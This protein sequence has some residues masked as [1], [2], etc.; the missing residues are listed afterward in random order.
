ME[1]E[2]RTPGP[3]ASG[4][5]QRVSPAQA[6][7]PPRSIGDIG[8][9]I[10][11]EAEKG[12][13]QNAVQT[14]AKAYLMSAEEAAKTYEADP[15]F[16]LTD[17]EAARRRGIYG[18]NA[19]EKQKKTGLLKQ[20]LAQLKDV[21]TIILIIAG[22]LSLTMSI[23]EWEGVHSLIEPLVVF[24]IIVMNVIL[25]VTQE[26]SAE[27]ALEALSSLSSPVC[28]VVRGGSVREADPA[29][30]VPGDLVMLKTGDLVPADARL[31][32]SESLAADE[33]SL[34][35]ES[36]PA[37]KD[38]SATF[39][40]EAPLGDRANCVYSGCLVTAGNAAAVVTATGMNTEMGKIARFLTDTKNK[41]TTL[42]VRL[43]KVGKVIS[44]IAVMS[45]V[46]LFVTGLIQGQGIMDMLLVAITLAVAAVP[47]TLALIVTLIL[48]YGAKKMATK[49]A[50]V[51]QMQAVETLGSTSVICSDKTGTLT[52]NKMTVK[53]LWVYGGEPVAESG[54]FSEG[55]NEFL[56]N[57]CLA[58]AAT[59]GTDDEG[60][61]KI[62][63]DPTETAIVRLAMEK[64]IDYQN[65]G[66]RYKKVA[67]IPF[68]SARKMMTNVIELEDGYLVLTKGA[69]DRLPF[70]RSDRNYMY[71]LERVHDGFAK[72]ALRV[73]ALASKKIDRLP[74]DI[75][76]VESGLTFGG[77]VG[78]IDPPRPEAAAAI[79]KAK[80]AG[81]RTVM[82]TGDHAATAGAIAR[83]LG[84]IAANEGVITGQE[85]ASLSDEELA[86]SVEFYSVYARVSPEDK[87]RIVKAWQSRG[88][89]VAMTGDGVNDAP[90]LKAADVGVA[91]G[92][93]GT[94]VSKSAAKMIL[95]DD[96]FSTIIEAVA[97]GRNIFSNI[98]KLVY[99]LLVCNISEILVMLFAQFMGWELPLTPLMLLII[100][101]L[102]DGIP[103][104]ALAKEESDKRIMKRKPISRNES[105]FGGGL[106]E[107]IIQQ[108]FVFAIVTL[109]GYYIGTHV[110]FGDTLPS[111]EAGRTMAFL[112]TGWTS[113]L[114]VLTV[115]SR[116]MLYK[117]RIK[118]NPQLYISCGVMLALFAVVA[119]VP[120]VASALGLGALGWQQ[121]LIVIAFSLVPL[122]VAEYGK[123]WDAIKSR[124]AERTAVR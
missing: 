99:F 66:S 89:V 11:Q 116:S 15:I 71:E 69:F 10:G 5:N 31:I 112:I 47:E 30:L 56:L 70:D 33:S 9:S 78:I 35:G 34:T 111:L 45:A 102:G 80:A 110:Q 41:K 120:P 76:D 94:E 61:Q 62:M 72:D 115:R 79:A 88:E 68:S 1:E 20:I 28:R 117:Y 65:L 101:V 18:A 52:M 108:I 75:A 83:E 97:E 57:L 121:W 17:E 109:A 21:S 16:G 103:G 82:I 91:M 46:V 64:G 26:R 37:E 6:E 40:E 48:S 36:V 114:H 63:G 38:A 13:T 100:N 59:V 105:F 86:D 77:F 25:A 53:R 12:A 119:A 7:Q 73:I 124:N 42:Q 90:A 123:L 3:P 24:A 8:G 93:N 106:M 43:D 4:E 58:C 98:R 113:I 14:A 107:V 39:S 55:Q 50:L 27:N 96:K 84:I 23:I 51:R 74:A 60:N 2:K 49:N 54:Q 67:E 32:R 87:I 85:L 44:G 118:D 19:F 92:I 122:L 22:I 29:E 81:I 95:T 104:L